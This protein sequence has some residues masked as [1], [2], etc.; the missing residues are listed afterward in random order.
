MKCL[1]LVGHGCAIVSLESFPSE[2]FLRKHFRD[3]IL[4]FADFS[5]T[6]HHCSPTSKK[7]LLLRD[8]LF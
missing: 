4:A 2:K 6:S 7:N 5:Q 8:L 1:G 3:V